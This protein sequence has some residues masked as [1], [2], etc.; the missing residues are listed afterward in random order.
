MGIKT[1]DP[2]FV[3]RVVVKGK[4]LIKIPQE[5]RAVKWSSIFA[6]SI[7]KVANKLGVEIE[8]KVKGDCFWIY[9]INVNENLYASAYTEES[10]KNMAIIGFDYHHFVDDEYFWLLTSVGCNNSYYNQLLFPNLCKC[11]DLIRQIEATYQPCHFER[12]IRFNRI[13]AFIYAYIKE[14]SSLKN[15]LDDVC[16]GGIYFPEMTP[17]ECIGKLNTL[18]V[19]EKLNSRGEPDKNDPIN[20]LRNSNR[21]FF[22]VLEYLWIVTEPPINCEL[23]LAEDPGTIAEFEAQIER[24]IKG[25]ILIDSIYRRFKKTSSRRRIIF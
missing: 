12:H 20:K 22:N 14:Y 11:P 10:A 9:I 24:H 2:D 13:S 16:K 3:N 25:M 5:E 1:S 6:R 19:T 23:F 17:D 18:G 15:Y 8:L 7:L 4:E 21:D